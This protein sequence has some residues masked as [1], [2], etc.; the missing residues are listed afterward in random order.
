MS[1]LGQKRTYA[2]QNGMSALPP[3][4]DISGA[5][6]Y[7][8]F[9]PSPDMCGATRMSALAKPGQDNAMGSREFL[10]RRPRQP[11]AWHCVALGCLKLRGL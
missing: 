10:D 4:A 7:V 11:P 9:G 6:A 5:Q 1:A 8:L 2:V 3:K